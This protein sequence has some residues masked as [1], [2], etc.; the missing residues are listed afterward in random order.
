MK[1]LFI[2]NRYKTSWWEMLAKEFETLGHEVCFLIQNHRFT[3]P[4]GKS[5]KMPYPNKNITSKKS[6]RFNLDKII[7]SNRGLNFFGI[8][9][10]SFIYHYH[11]IIDKYVKSYNPDIVFGEST[12]FHELLT[13]YSCKH[14][15]ILYLNPSSCRYPSGRFSFYLYDTLEPYFSSG[16]VLSQNEALNIINNITKKTAVPDYMKNLK[17]QLST[18]EVIFDRLNLMIDFYRGERFNTPSPLIFLKLR[19]ELK[20]NLAEW[21]RISTEISELNKDTFYIMYPL[22]MQPEANIDV[23]GYENSNQL[24]VIKSIFNLLD[25]N[26]VLIIKL[27]PKSKYELSKELLSF[28]KKHKGKVVAVSQKSTMTQLWP[29]IKLI[30]TVTGTVSIECVLDNKPLIALGQGIQMKEKNCFNSLNDF[31]K[32]V[33][34]VKTK[35]YPR[36][37]N[38]EKV[39]FLNKLVSTSHKGVNGDGLHNKK[40]KAEFRVVLKAYLKVLNKLEQS[41]LN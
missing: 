31:R 15:N 17:Y 11:E 28:I 32:V 10:D 37:L 39:A 21:G 3:P 36:L 41:L 7:E 12:T 14:Q 19:L 18:Q 5:F 40:Y 22:Q 8:K 9:S 23:W 35:K 16:D 27:N 13:I 4:I 30:I 20:K 29:L 25:E 38:Q 24:N 2:E 34:L 26:E 1:I 33:N 6:A